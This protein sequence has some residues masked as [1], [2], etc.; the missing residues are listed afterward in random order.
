[1]FV[2]VA[3]DL[4]RRIFRAALRFE[5]A[6]IA[7]ELAGTIK[8]RLAL[9]HGTTRAKP[10]PARAVVDVVGRVVSKVATRESAVAPPMDSS[11]RI[12]EES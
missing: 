4:A 5:W 1:M 12:T 2:D 7:V 8:K 3:R 9:M 6:Y 11:R 10:L